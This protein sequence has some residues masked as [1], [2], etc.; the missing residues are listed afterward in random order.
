M[1]DIITQLKRQNTPEDNVYPNIKSDNI[2]DSAILESKIANSAV[3]SGKIAD[4]AVISNKIA[5]SAVTSGKIANNAVASGK[6]ADSAITSA[7]LANNA[8]THGKIPVDSQH[9]Q[10]LNHEQVNYQHLIKLN[11]SGRV[12]TSGAYITGCLVEENTERGRYTTIS[13]PQELY[14]YIESGEFILLQGFV[15][16]NNNDL[17]TIINITASSNT[18]NLIYING[19]SSGIVTIPYADLN[20][21]F[22]EYKDTL[23]T[24]L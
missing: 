19:T 14:S 15:E 18:L 2:P 7:K 9:P 13:D 16:D 22:D 23:I 24:T 8:V 3:T 5:D 12:Y 4:S 11:A 6:I 1:A 10:I 21:E 17:Y 20:D